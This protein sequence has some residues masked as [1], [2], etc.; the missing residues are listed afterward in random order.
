MIQYL[1]RLLTLLSLG[2]AQNPCVQIE[3]DIGTI[4]IEFYPIQAPITV[5]NFLKY[6][7]EN[8][9]EDFHFYRV[10][11]LNNQPDNDLKIEVI[12]GGLGFDKHPMELPPIQHE[13]T[14]KTGILHEDGTISMARLEPGTASSEIFICI[15]DQPEL[16]FGGKRNP[17][18]QGFAAFGKVI[19]GMDIV[20]QI[21]LMP[22]SEQML[23]KIVKI[24]SIKRINS[25]NDCP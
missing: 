25:D 24:K 22:E 11:H 18:G 16:D 6:M 3:T 8:R 10:V 13:T 7:D 2:F 19:F 4:K 12:Q 14:E 5:A 15:G 17:D 9:Y 23:D 21:Q 1:F 20:R